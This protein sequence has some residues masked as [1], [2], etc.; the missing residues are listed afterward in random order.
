MIYRVEIKKKIFDNE[1]EILKK[2][3]IE[4][5]NINIEDLIIVKVFLFKTSLKK[6][7]I[8]EI[9]RNL[10]L[11]PVVE[12]FK[13]GNF[14]FK[15]YKV[16]EIGYNLGV[17]DPEEEQV[18]KSL[19]EFGYS[20]LQIKI[21]KKYL[22]KTKEKKEKL[23]EIAKEHLYNPLIQH[24]IKGKPNYL[25]LKPKEYKFKLRRVKI[26][27]KKR[28][29]LIKLAKK[30]S[31]SLPELLAIQRYYQK[32]KREPTDIEIET[33]AQTWSE[34][35]K[36]KT[37]K[38]DVYYKGKWIRNLLKET[39]FKVTE[40]L[41]KPYV[42]LAFRDNSG[43]IE[44]D[45]NYGISF[46]VETHNH[47]SAIEPYGGAATG[48]GGVIRD[49]L[50]TGLGSKPILNTDIFCFGKLD[51]KKKE[52]PKGVLPPRR[53]LKGV[54]SGVRDYGNRMGIPTACGAVYFH[55]NFLCNPLVFCGTLGI[56]PKDKIEKK[57]I[58]ND[59]IVLVGGDTGRDGIHGVTFAS[60]ELKRESKRVASTAVQIGNPI[61]EKKM[62]DAILQARDE[63]LF[64]AITDCGGGGLSSAI[65]E[66]SEKTGAEVYL[67][68]V[69]LKYAGLSYTEIWIS[70][71]Q[72]RMII[73]LPEENFKRFK[74]ICDLHNVK[75]TIIGRLRDDK[76]LILKYQDKIVGEIDLNFLHNGIPQVKRKAICKRKEKIKKID[77]EIK[78]YNELLLKI[79]KQE[80]V[81]SKEWIIRQYDLEVQ[82][83]T[84][85]KPLLEGSPSDGVILK[86]LREKDK[87]IAVACGINPS[88]GEIS[89]YWMAASVVDEALRNVVCCGGDINQTG[90]LDNF[91]FSNP[92][93]EE[94]MGDI[95][96]T[97]LGAYFAAKGYQT[98]FISGK[99]SLYNE[100]RIGKKTIAIPPTLL[101]SA[102]SIIPNI[103]KTIT[104]YFKKPKS[105]IILIGET[106]NE[107]GGSV[108]FSLFNKNFGK[109]P[110]V[111]PEKGR[112][113]ME[114]IFE[115]IN[116]DLII[117]IHDLSEGGLGVALAEMT[118]TQNLGCKIDLEKVI[119]GE[120]INRP[121]IILF[122]ESNTR[123]LCEVEEEKIEEFLRLMGDIKLAILGEVLEK[124]S[125][126][127]NYYNKNLIDLE[128]KLLRENWEKGLSLQI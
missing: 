72:E 78:D 77:W 39:I 109:V 122:S 125:L 42:L 62:V 73:F 1:S 75:A 61:E 107:L 16:I 11:D 27:N 19:N 24:I 114:K 47:P 105:K 93:R 28:K 30:F 66:L 89:P 49:C 45:E 74:E 48:I 86:P 20:S 32:L 87:G 46:K 67:D 21:L 84:V 127:I 58:P 124:D 96:E 53:I 98:P 119:L 6:N 76:K 104:S 68:K 55:K 3:L 12:E 63:N 43:V 18:I 10:F 85:L 80:N 57:I 15:G 17:T 94:V 108:Y 117:S 81:A 33:F 37:M 106:Y 35:C 88:Y 5:F 4:N 36:H 69:P 22:F 34:H 38:G 95:V 110:R 2:E 26:L 70:E 100:F 14:N 123:F 101:I 128:I 44:F 65:G 126:I 25:F 23:V 8:E 116:K 115:A 7:E 41:N 71:S 102:V 13:I 9:V 99:D 83:R 90:I 31:L 120:E 118:F 103:N 79:I 51:I 121:D 52:I 50:G 40:E 54:V 113:I 60:G 29:E 112:K 56:I 97:C 92:E 91:C 59:I 111:F 82:G 64:N